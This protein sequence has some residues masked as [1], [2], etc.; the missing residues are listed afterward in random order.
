VLAVEVLIATEA[1][2]AVI[3]EGKTPQLFNIMQT[4]ARQGM[5]TLETSLNE[6]VQ[7]RVITYETAVAK[8]NFPAQIAPPVGKAP[9]PP[10]SAPAGAPGTYPATPR[11]GASAPASGLPDRAASLSL[12]TGGG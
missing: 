1:V 7:R 11:R 4:S 12:R 2:R 6:L 10:G 5:L 9:G 8:A 3:R